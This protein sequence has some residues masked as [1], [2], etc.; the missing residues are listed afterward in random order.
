M[1]HL[2]GAG[3]TTAIVVALVALVA[4]TTACQ[5]WSQFLGSPALTGEA[6]AETAITS[7]NVSTLAPVFWSRSLGT[8]RTDGAP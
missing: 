4:M 1:R 5:N 2:R 7:A 6:P 8:T 3:R